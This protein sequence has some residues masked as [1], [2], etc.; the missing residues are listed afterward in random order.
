MLKMTKDIQDAMQPLLVHIEKEEDD[1]AVNLL[2]DMN[3]NDRSE[4]LFP[5]FSKDA[6]P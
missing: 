1:E 6:R 3:R 4:S 2:L 5:S